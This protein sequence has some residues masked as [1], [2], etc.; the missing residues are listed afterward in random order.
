METGFILA[1]SPDIVRL[2]DVA[3]VQKARLPSD[4]QSE[5]YFDGPPDLAVEVTSPS[6]TSERIDAKVDEYLSF[7]TRLVWVVNQRRQNVVVYRLGIPPLT[8]GIVDTLEGGEVLPRF[9][10]KVAEIME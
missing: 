9:A 10:V 4:G 3:F 6:E 5:L 7:G 2:P 1:R 8:L